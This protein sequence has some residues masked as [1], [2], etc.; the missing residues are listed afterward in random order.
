MA[1][2]RTRRAGTSRFG[3]PG[4]NVQ[5]IVHVC[6]PSNAAGAGVADKPGILALD[7]VADSG[8]ITTRYLWIDSNGAVRTHTAIPTNQDGDG[9]LI[10]P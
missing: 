8:V 6:G 3:T 2:D 10:G 4:R 5:G 9:I 1:Q 7:S